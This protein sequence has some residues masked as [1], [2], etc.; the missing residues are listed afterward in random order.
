MSDP[1]YC[2]R[3]APAPTGALHLG[4]A[5]TFLITWLRCRSMGGRLILRMED[6]DHPKTKPGAAEQA[7]ADLLWLG[8]DW[9]EGP[10]QAMRMLHEKKGGNAPAA[11]DRLVDDKYI[12][13]H[14]ADIYAEKF[15]RL[16]EQGLVYACTC[17]RRD[18]VNAQSAPHPGEELRYPGTCR[19][20]TGNEDTNDSDLPAG[21][22]AW[23]FRIDDRCRTTF[24][25]VF[26]GFQ[27]SRLFDWSGDFVIGRMVPEPGQRT[28]AAPAFRAAY[29]L[30]VVVDDH[31]MGVTEVIRGDDLLPSTHR[32][33]VL[34]RALGWSPPRFLHLPLVVGP[35]NR[36][37]AKRHGDTRIASLRAAGVSA[38]EL[39]GRLANTCGLA[40]P[41]ELLLPEDL[42]ERFILDKI[43]RERV[44]IDEADTAAGKASHGK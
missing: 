17:S 38:R 39:I 24:N 18:I 10:A 19:F 14:R 41:G 31:L 23:R 30:A 42:L 37:L 9:D 4:N 34:Y 44:I 13:S 21:G 26:C 5:R 11:N 35:D 3:F 29:Q 40:K 15:A 28:P 12:Q 25:D 22:F 16:R 20:R 43:P 36:R 2:T 7:Y 27:Q 6:L 32:Q 8:L 33:L 1:V